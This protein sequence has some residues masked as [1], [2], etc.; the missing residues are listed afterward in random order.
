MSELKEP[1]PVQ[2]IA[3]VFTP[4]R[5][6]LNQTIQGL[7]EVYGPIERLSEES[8]FDRTRY[9]AREMG[10]PLYRRFLSF[11][12]LVPPERLVDIKIETRD[13]ERRSAWNGNR[14]V[15]ID[16]GYIAPERL[17]LAT[18]KNYVH[19]IYLSRGVYADLTLVYKRKSFRALDWTYPD[20]ADSTS[21][22]FFNQLRS[23]YMNR[24]REMRRLDT[25]HDGIR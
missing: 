1:D 6:L 17:V 12:R 13:I 16:P 15:N 8:R 23:D 11:E 9:Y 7:S 19:R 24:L 14:R 18:G 21:I 22:E 20:Y 3:S 25:E 10:W 2:L 4:D 5:G